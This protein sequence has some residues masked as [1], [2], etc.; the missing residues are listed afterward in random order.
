[1][2]HVTVQFQWQ[3]SYYLAENVREN[4]ATEMP[5]IFQNIK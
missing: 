1:M 4:H 3:T 5:V 2:Q